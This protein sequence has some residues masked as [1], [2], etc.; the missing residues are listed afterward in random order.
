MTTTLRIEIFS[1]D[2]DATVD[3][4]TRVFG[5][6]LE[7]DQRDGSPGYV[8]L[9]R[10][11]VRIGVAYRDVPERQPGRR[12]PSGTEIVLEVDDLDTEHARV[13]AAGWPIEEGLTDREWGLR[14]FRVLDPSGYYLRLTSQDRP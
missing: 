13:V 1:A 9:E 4:Y 14:D 12:P 7:R 10:D 8:A 6:T 5:F 11:R 2:L 3:F